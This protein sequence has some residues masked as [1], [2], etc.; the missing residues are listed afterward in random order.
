MKKLLLAILLILTASYSYAQL[1]SYQSA[2]L[3]SAQQ[4]TTLLSTIGGSSGSGNSVYHNTWL[5][6]NVTGNNW[7]STR[8]H[9]GIS[10][11]NSFLNPQINTLTWWE[12]DPNANI[13]SW[14]TNSA[15]YLTINNGNVG[16]GITN[17]QSNLSVKGY[18]L[19]TNGLVMRRR[20]Y[21]WGS[22]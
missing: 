17:P 14:G 1:I 4:G 15:T 16:I 2:P 20:L 9:D 7:Y 21:R 3:P 12:R 11:D 6:R 5:V 13:Q 18:T 22:L 8:V 10:V 19:P